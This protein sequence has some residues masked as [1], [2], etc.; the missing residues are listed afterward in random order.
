MFFFYFNLDNFLKNKINNL[1]SKTN[2]FYILTLKNM[3]QINLLKIYIQNVNYHRSLCG[4]CD[5]CMNLENIIN[6]QIKENFVITR[7]FTSKINNFSSF[8]STYK[9]KKH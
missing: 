3:N 4:N 6:K 5:F 7:T 8:V 9:K 2:L 1:D